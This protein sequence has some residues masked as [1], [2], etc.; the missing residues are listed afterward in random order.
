MLV[1]QPPAFALSFGATG[2][3]TSM[4]A[5]KM[6][7]GSAMRTVERIG[8]G[9]EAGN[10]QNEAVEKHLFHDRWKNAP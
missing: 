5:E 4:G 7:P 8:G 9:N 1:G 2:D 10:L 6:N 3:A